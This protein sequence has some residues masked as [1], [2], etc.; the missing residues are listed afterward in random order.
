MNDQTDNTTALR[1]QLLANGYTPLPN[2]GKT[3]YLEGWPKVEVTPELLRKWGRRHKRWA[4]TGIRIQDGLAVIDLDVDHAL[5]IDLLAALDAAFPALSL[6]LCRYGKGYKVA[7]FCRTAEPFTRIH[8]YRVTAPGETVEEHGTHCV[9]IFGGASPRQFGAFGAHTR[10][11]DGNVVISYSWAAYDEADNEISPLTVALADLPEFDKQTFFAIAGFCE[12]W[13]LEHGFTQVMLTKSGESEVERVFDLTDDMLFEDNEGDDNVPLATVRDKAKAGVEGYRV[14][15]SFIEPG[16]QHSRT[17][18]LV[19]RAHGGELTIWDSATGVTHME[20]SLSPA[21]AVERQEKTDT[22][23]AKL[24]RLAE[25]ENERKTKRRARLSSEDDHLTASGKLL[26]THAWCPQQQLGVVPIYATSTTEGMTLANFRTTMLPW[27]GIEIGERGGEKK[28][29]PVD[30]WSSSKERVTVEGL[31]M[32]PD[33]PRPLYE[34][35]G[36]KFINTYSP[37]L[38]DETGGDPW[39]GQALLEQLLPDPVERAWFTQWLAYKWLHPEV[40]GPAVLMVARGFGTGRGTLG[41]LVKHMFGRQYVSTIGFDHFAGR[42]YQSQYTEWQADALVVIVNE[43]STA[44]NGSSFRTKH[45]TYER[46]KETVDPRVQERTIVAKGAKAYKALVFASYLIFTNNPDA[47]PLPAEDRRFWVGTNG[48]PREPEFWDS[49]NDWMAVPANVAAFTRWLEEVDLS[50]YDPYKKPPHT[51]AK[52]GM[53]D[54]NASDLDRAFEEALSLLPGR[55][56]VPEQVVMMIRELR[57]RSGYDLPDRWE[58]TA[59]KMVYAKLIKI[60]LKDGPGYVVKFGGKKFRT[61]ART[62]AEA[63]KWENPSY[64]THGEAALNGDPSAS[65]SPEELF[66]KL[67]LAVGGGP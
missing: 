66:R 47:L 16:R 57:T 24:K 44:D 1:L 42:T 18:C 27:C 35:R 67:K 38:H 13:L 32:R 23:A 34:E 55:V 41:D 36:K 51:R 17:R 30:L 22:L 45:D 15:A 6:T 31:R 2:V 43:S 63:K 40:P 3:T 11:E 56:I 61:Y 65:K 37:E 48:A 10:D 39:G 19:G 60:G 33:M 29:N 7:L 53:V 4:D 50:S 62:D 46:L 5:A 52:A 49:I 9:E 54:M 21:N 14:S 25:H 28:I 20:A 8:T 26:Q 58:I 59:K 12:R 64:N